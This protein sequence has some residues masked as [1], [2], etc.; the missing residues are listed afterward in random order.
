MLQLDYEEHYTDLEVSGISF[1]NTIK[2]IC[3]SCITNVMK[4]NN[5]S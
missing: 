4:Y 5:I 2:I 3:P 1:L